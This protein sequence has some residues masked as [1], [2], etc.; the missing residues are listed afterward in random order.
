MGKLGSQSKLKAYDLGNG[1]R[2]L[3][4]SRVLEWQELDW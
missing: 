3:V 1:H 4:G 2:E